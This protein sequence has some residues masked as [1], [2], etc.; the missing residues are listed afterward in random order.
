[1]KENSVMK[2]LILTIGSRGDVQPYVALGM[3]LRDAGHEVRIG[4]A[5]MFEGFVVD[6]GLG[7]APLPDDLVALL[8]AESGQ[9]AIEDMQGPFGAV[10]ATL[11]LLKQ[12]KPIIR[13]LMLESWRAADEFR[14]D[15]LIYN[16]KLPG[17]HIAEKL[18]VP[19]ALAVPF[20]QLVATSEMPTLGMPELGPFNKSS[21]KMV[22]L[23]MGVFAGFHNT[24]RKD[25]LGLDNAPRFFG[26]H[27]MTDG[28]E[29]PV[30][31]C[32]SKHV[33][34]R[35]VDW[36]GSVHVTGYWFME[37]KSSPSDELVQFLEKGEPPVY[38]GFGSMSGRKTAKVTKVV[39]DAIQ[40]A[41]VR[42]VIATGWGGLAADE[43]PDSILMIDQAPHEW[44]FPRVSAVVHHGGAGT[45]AAGLR[46]GRPTVICPF[47]GDQPFWGKI[48]YD[49]GFG[50]KPIP[51]RKLSVEKLSEAIAEVTSNKEMIANAAAVGEKI[52]S[53]N[54]VANAIAI[55]E[56]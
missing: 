53:E 30:L 18:E 24:F 44:L 19:C 11:R 49:S 45:T 38:V 27:H 22:S 54:G 42:G 32:F 33:C 12:I 28:T 51:Q 13:G 6:K 46:A 21:Y 37:D 29:V 31:H 5:A 15:Y 25:V 8:T 23:F 2:I 9:K 10:K 39:I 55:I 40:K 50:P 36:P 41:N 52:R 20:P 16:S 48:I 56:G 7:F 47:F 34:P 43:L 26:L 1:M 4:T 17:V 14:P 35:P 3:G